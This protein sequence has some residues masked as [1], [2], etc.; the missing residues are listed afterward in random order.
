MAG[1]GITSS[2]RAS[3]AATLIYGATIDERRGSTGGGRGGRRRRVT[4]PSLFFFLFFPRRWIVED[5][6]ISKE[7]CARARVPLAPIMIL[8]EQRSSYIR[9]HA[10]RNSSLSATTDGH[11]AVPRLR[12]TRSP[13]FSSLVRFL[14]AAGERWHRHRRMEEG[15]GPRLRRFTEGRGRRV[16]LT[17]FCFFFFFLSSMSLF[18]CLA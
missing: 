8:D 5:R 7:F 6:E 4:C 3:L 13:R 11:R 1:R 2:D 18:G 9:V 15:R 17:G 14:F 16:V 12:K 10:A